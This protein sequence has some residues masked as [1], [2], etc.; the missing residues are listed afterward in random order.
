MEHKD[1]IELS[2]KQV[3]EYTSHGVPV[4]RVHLQSPE[5]A[6]ALGRRPGTYIT[7][8]TGPLDKLAS[9]KNVCSCLVEQ[10]RPLLSPYFGKTLCVCCLGNQAVPSD[11]LGPETA[12]RF[13]PG[14]YDSLG[15][16]SNF[17]KTA[18]ICPGVNGQ[19][20]LSTQT[21]IS[22]VVSTIGAACVLAV[23]SCLSGDAER[24]CSTIQMNSGGMRTYWDTADICS[25]TVNVP[26]ISICVP[27]AIRM[28]DLCRGE[29]VEDGPF[30]SPVHISTIINVASFI[31]ACAVTQ[32]AYPELDYESCKRYIELFLHDIA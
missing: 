28:V 3:E 25:S 1:F 4:L 13:R 27:T 10:L 21:I 29:S 17:L 24:L 20:N 16:K 9:F 18:V 2:N 22:G 11:T 15:M 26:V 5:A 12:L 19:T 6:E 31:I 14:A 8:N 23:D 32:V 30:L 7:L